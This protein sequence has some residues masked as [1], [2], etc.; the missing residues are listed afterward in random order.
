MPIFDDYSEAIGQPFDGDGPAIGPPLNGHYLA[1]HSHLADHST[2]ISRRLNH[3]WAIFRRL[4]A[5]FS[6]AI[7]QRFLAFSWIFDGIGHVVSNLTVL[8]APTGPARALRS[9]RWASPVNYWPA[10]SSLCF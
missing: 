10:S 5:G 1:I 6:P 3:H 9:E 2:I 4:S 7:G 8:A